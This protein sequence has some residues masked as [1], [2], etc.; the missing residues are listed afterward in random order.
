MVQKLPASAQIFEFLEQLIDEAHQRGGLIEHGMP[1]YQVEMWYTRIASILTNWIIHPET[2]FSF[3]DLEEICLRKTHF[4]YIFAASGYRGMGHIIPLIG[5]KDVDDK[6]VIS[7]VKL[8]VI[9][10][11]LPLDDISDD[12]MAL[13]MNLLRKEE[14]LLF[15][16]LMSWINQRAVLTEQGERNRTL[17][18]ASSKLIENVQI[19]DKHLGMLSRAY[20]FCT[21][22]TY[23]HKHEIKS[24]I[25][26][27]MAE[28]MNRAGIHPKPAVHNNSK[29][30]PKLLVVL[31]RW[32]KIHAMYRCYAP[33]MNKLKEKFEL[34]ALVDNIDIDSDSAKCFN[35]VLKFDKTKKSVK[36]IAH[37]AER[38]APDLVYYPSIGMST[39]VIMLSNLRLAPIQ[40]AS[41]GHPATTRSPHIDYVF[42]GPMEGDLDKVLSERILI[43]DYFLKF[44][45]HPESPVGHKEKIRRDGVIRIAA[46]SKV[47]KL[48][49]RY[50][51]ICKKI[52]ENSQIPVEFHFFPAERGVYHDGI[53]FEIKKHIPDA[54]VHCQTSYTNFL[55]HLSQC[56]LS[57][58]AFPFGNTNSTVDATILGIPTICHFGVEPSSQT[59]K[60]VSVIAGLPEFLITET[61]DEYYATALRVINDENFRSEFKRQ[62][63][64]GAVAD[65]LFSS[66]DQNLDSGFTRMIEFIYR[67][68]K[69]LLHRKIIKMSEVAEVPA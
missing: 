29:K 12:L 23:E 40:I 28:R 10:A 60:L 39:W 18:L 42:V 36:D 44:E 21:Y 59:D 43:G 35:R 54:V 38:E 5:E 49:Y 68:N 61:D 20:M 46:N 37:M 55:T 56:D 4:Q 1:I 47:M 48:S 31:E 51:E 6:F 64:T 2:V 32:T 22:A 19:E 45:P 7:S 66:N 58:A 11:V 63:Q 24:V 27:L 26:K 52:K 25:N 53:V 16:Y 14:K 50:V 41:Q 3:S 30:R 33:I 8:P 34:I 15:L 65:K 62:C 17:L 57:L 13:A 67:N 9:L 69:D